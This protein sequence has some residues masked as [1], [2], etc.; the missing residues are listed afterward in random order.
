MP[1][2]ESSVQGVSGWAWWVVR[3]DGDRVS[4]PFATR[5]EAERIWRGVYDT[6]EYRVDYQYAVGAPS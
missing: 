3:D 5:E 1:E 6:S 4:G 2:S